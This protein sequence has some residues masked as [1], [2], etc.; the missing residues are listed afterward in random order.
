MGAICQSAA[1]TDLDASLSIAQVPTLEKTNT[2]RTSKALGIIL[3]D[4]DMMSSR[5]PLRI[6]T[7]YA[8]SEVMIIPNKV[9]KSAGRVIGAK[10]SWTLQ[11]VSQSKLDHLPS[12]I[13]ADLGR[14][15]YLSERIS[16]Q[17]YRNE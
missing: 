9:L 17:L 8:Q 1:P 7:A 14:G 12:S 2:R 5:T 6:D 15:Q 16:E 13:A 4:F 11:L 3:I 10:S